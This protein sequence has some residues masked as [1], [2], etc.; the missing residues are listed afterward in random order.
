MI[1]HKMPILLT[2]NHFPVSVLPLTLAFPQ[3]AEAGQVLGLE[4]GM[5]TSIIVRVKNWGKGHRH[6]K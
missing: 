2:P 1:S 6:L 5:A 4:Q 3:A